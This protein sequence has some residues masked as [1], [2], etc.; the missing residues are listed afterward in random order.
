MPEKADLISAGL[1]IVDEVP[2][3]KPL[4]PGDLFHVQYAAL[5]AGGGDA[6]YFANNFYIATE[7]FVQ[8]HQ[9]ITDRDID[10]HDL[11]GLLGDR[12]SFLIDL[13]PYDY[14]GTQDITLQVPH[15]VSA[16]KYYL[17]M[18]TDDDNEVPETNEFNNLDYV[19]I[20]IDGPGDLFNQHLA[21]L[22]ENSEDDPLQPGEVFTAEY[23][24]VNKGGEDVPF[25]ATHFY[26]LTEDYLNKHETIKVEDIDNIEL[27]ALYGDQF[28]EVITLGAFDSTGM[29]EIDLQI[30]EGIKPGKYYLGMQS[31]VFAEVDEF[32]ELN[33]SLFAPVEDYVEIYIG[34]VI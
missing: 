31:D 19:E 29:Q 5:N 21:V 28:S 1:Q 20:Y 4:K 25:S 6:P 11:Y 3:N 23:E 32:Y 10:F 33:N 24:V 8:S 18:Q 22:D 16:G 30:P 26:L 12:D 14:T 27:Y 7:D 17:V 2:Q 9:Q 15:N 34:D 13:E